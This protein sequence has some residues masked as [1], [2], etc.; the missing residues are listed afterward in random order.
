VKL[1]RNQPMHANDNIDDDGNSP[2]SSDRIEDFWNR[3]GGPGAKET[4]KG[5]T[6]PGISGW[7]EVS[8]ADGYILRCDWSRSGGRHEMQF[9]EKPPA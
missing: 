9:I 1:E 2:D 8:A 7:T 6:L 5:H 4:R 3:H